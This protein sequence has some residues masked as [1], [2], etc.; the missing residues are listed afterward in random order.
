MKKKF[1]F[2]SLPARLNTLLVLGGAVVFTAVLFDKEESFVL[3]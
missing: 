1:V 2:T 3:Y